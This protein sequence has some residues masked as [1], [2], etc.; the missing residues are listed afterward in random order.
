MLPRN[1][2]S[3]I[4]YF[5]KR[6]PLAVIGFLIITLA[7][8]AEI[9]FSPYV[10]KMTIDAVSRNG[11]N[12]NLLLQAVMLPAII[13]VALTIGHN[14]VMRVF[15]LI[16]LKFFPKLRVEISTALFGHLT[17]HSVSYFQRNFSG[18]LANKIQGAVDGVES[19]IKLFIRFILGN[20]FTILITFILLATVGIYFSIVLLIWMLIY[21]YVGY[22]YAKRTAQ[23]AYQYSTA[24][25]Q[26]SGQLVDSIANIVSAKIFANV[27]HEAARINR[28]VSAVGEQAK[29]MEWQ[30]IGSDF[31][32]N[33]IFTLF[34]A[35]LLA[36][37]IY[38]RI[39]GWVTVGDFAFIIA[40]SL[41]I[42]S[43]VNAFTKCL[44]DLSRDA[45][46]CSQALHA[47]VL[48]VDHPD[49]PDATILQVT[50]SSV[51]FKN[52]NF[53][54]DARVILSNFSLLI[55][56]KQKVGLVGYSGAGKTTLVNL[57]L[58]LFEIQSGSITIDNVNINQVTRDSLVKNIALIPQQPE[59]F[60]RSIID[61]IRYG[62]TTAS[63]ESVIAAA[64]T[65]RCHEFISQ[66]PNSYKTIVGERGITLS[67]GQKQ[68]ISIARAIL[69][70]APILILDEATSAL[71]SATEHEI[72]EAFQSVMQDK[73]VLVIAHRLSTIKSMDRILF[74]DQGVIKEDGCFDELKEQKGL[75]AK[76]LEMQMFD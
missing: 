53:S 74:M 64:K 1:L 55:P 72:Q 63:D 14:V 13:Y 31:Y 5:L 20:F 67:G 75:F 57:L 40:T 19:I 23:Y 69:K 36:G 71:D 76:L 56:A 30:V 62:D 47:I 27:S 25:N 66:L 38:G 46:K 32:Q 29:L 70:N 34:I 52:V 21:I 43:M 51:S 15:H 37:L 39:E 42:C 68:R 18:D 28:A 3:F 12:T 8:S 49:R 17:R 35:F 26:L 50:N 4:V 41:N 16:S 61:N 45:G 22:V 60:H 48:P 11:D 24:N 7:A 10:L 58:R 44:P 6:H 65:A 54:Y 9:S 73:T 33:I 2:I 59:L